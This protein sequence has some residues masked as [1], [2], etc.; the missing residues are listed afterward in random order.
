MN[1]WLIGG[2]IYFAAL[3]FAMALCRVAATEDD[4]EV[5]TGACSTKPKRRS[6]EY[7][8]LVEL[9]TDLISVAI[10]RVTEDDLPE[11][12]HS[13]PGARS[14]RPGEL[15]TAARRPR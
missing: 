12:H 7:E 3:L 14:H 1:V 8:E 2:G 11:P 10:H 15:Q 5:Q 4:P 6:A 13:R 9:D